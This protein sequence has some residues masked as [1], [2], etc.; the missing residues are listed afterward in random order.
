MKSKLPR[1]GNIFLE[2]AEN[3]RGGSAVNL[4]KI[5]EEV[6]LK[7]PN[8]YNYEV[9]IVLDDDRRKDRKK[10][11]DWV[12]D[13][14]KN[15]QKLAVSNPMFE[16]WLLMHFNC[17][18]TFSTKEE[19]QK[20][21]GEVISEIVKQPYEYGNKLEPQFISIDRIKNACDLA[22]GREISTLKDWPKRGFTNVD[23]LLKRILN[24]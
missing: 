19:Y 23:L 6:T 5:A 15:K 21:L 1:D 17:V 20:K 11:L 7:I 4:T 3:F 14:K 13:D 2:V 18:E 9:W 22:R 24:I 12:K 16:F 10:L 8:E